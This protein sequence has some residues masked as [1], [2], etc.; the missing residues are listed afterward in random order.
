MA[1][2]NP[3]TSAPSAGATE[4]AAERAPSAESKAGSEGSAPEAPVEKETENSNGSEEKP[5]GTYH[6]LFLVFILFSFCFACFEELSR[7][8]TG[9]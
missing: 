7:F 6:R 1:E 2:D 8:P 4:P 9:R 5:A 3:T